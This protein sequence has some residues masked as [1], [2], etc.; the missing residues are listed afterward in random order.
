MSSLKRCSIISNIAAIAAATAALWTAL[1]GLWIAA[2]LSLVAAILCALCSL[3]IARGERRLTDE[4][5]SIR[6][7]LAEARR[8]EE[9]RRAS[10]LSLGT[11]LEGSAGRTVSLLHRLEG[12]AS[13]TSDGIKVLNECLANAAETH[14]AA[15]VAQGSARSAISSYCSEVEAESRAVKDMVEAV[16]KLSSWSK[17]KGEVARSLLGRAAEAEDKLLEIGKAS[18]RM[19]AAAR[20]TA[21]FN[22]VIADLADR[23]N[24]LALNASVEAAHAGSAGKGF[25]V[26]AA[27]VRSLSEE[28]RKNSQ[29]VSSAI[30]GTLRSIGE[31]ASAASD[32]SDYFRSVVAQMKE[33]SASFESILAE[34]DSLSSGSKRIS[35]SL[36]TVARLNVDSERALGSSEESMGRSRDSLGVVRD[37]ASDI[38][39]DSASM[40]SAFKENLAEAERTRALGGRSSSAGSASST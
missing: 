23:T 40:M 36:E 21:A 24:L 20:N 10:S 25:A 18:E 38:G 1:S 15:L 6:G 28:S 34:L 27:Q 5:A 39:R 8:E 37:I 30:D 19:V 31:T 13:G 16:D 9:E 33:I 11:E 2:S 12:L 29:S 7:D 14:E 35:S 4:I 3:A 22:G 17:A 26:V 32:A